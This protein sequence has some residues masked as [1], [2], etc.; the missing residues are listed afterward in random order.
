MSFHYEEYKEPE[1]Q[2]V[3]PVN[4]PK[5]VMALISSLTILGLCAGCVLAA[6]LLTP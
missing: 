3:E 5:V 4:W 2:Q 6:W 1:A